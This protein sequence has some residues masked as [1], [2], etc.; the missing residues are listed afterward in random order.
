MDDGT[1]VRV[2]DRGAHLAK[3]LQ[4]PGDVERV[5]V[6]IL[7]DRQPLDVLHDEVRQ[8]VL[9]RAAVEQ[10][11]D[12]RVIEASEDLAL[13]AE[14]AQHRLR[15]H[16]ALD[17][18]DRDLF[19]VLAVGAPREIDRAHSAAAD[20][21]QDFPVA[22]GLADHAIGLLGAKSFSSSVAI[23]ASMKPPDFS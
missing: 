18:L 14:A 6:A 21:L 8:A 15:I 22:D 3:E 4:P 16:A 13:V 5:L 10:P 12:V 1:A 11:R 7:V 9:G 19:L 23:G 20:A 17:E 2:G